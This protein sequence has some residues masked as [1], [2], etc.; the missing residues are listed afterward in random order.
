MA[1]TL[2]KPSSG[3]KIQGL[4]MWGSTAR[5]PT[6]T[7]AAQAAEI[8]TSIAQLIEISLEKPIKI[9][10]KIDPESLEWARERPWDLLG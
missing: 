6:M 7:C 1:K 2:K 10:W 4:A 5:H 3:A 8:A 9:P